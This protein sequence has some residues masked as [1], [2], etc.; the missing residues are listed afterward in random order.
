MVILTAATGLPATDV[1]TIKKRVIKE[2]IRVYITNSVEVEML[3]AMRLALLRAETERDQNRARADHY[4]AEYA[5]AKAKL[6]ELEKELEDKRKTL[7]F[8][9]VLSR[10]ALP[11]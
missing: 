9:E 11:V 5:K 4:Q 8:L 1:D 6:A 10:K 2:G 7:G 3:T